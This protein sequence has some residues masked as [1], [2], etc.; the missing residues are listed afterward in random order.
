MAT[1]ELADL[2]AFPEGMN[3][4]AKLWAIPDS[5][6]RW[7]ED[8][9]LDKENEVDR[10][11]PVKP[12][13]VWPTSMT[14]K[15][16]GLVATDDPAYRWRVAVLH[17]TATT[18]K[19]SILSTS[20]S[21]LTEIQWA[22][23]EGV[24]FDPV[25]R[26]KVAT[27]IHPR[28]GALIG[29]QNFASQRGQTSLAHWGGAAKEVY[30][31]GTVTV[32]QDATAVSSS[33]AA[34]TGNIEAGMFLYA[35]CDIATG[36]GKNYIGQVSSFTN[37]TITLVEGALFAVTARA[38]Q[39][40]SLRPLDRRIA[41]GTITCTTSSATVNGANTK[42]KRQG[43]AASA[44]NDK[45]AL[46]RADDMKYIGLISSVASDIQ[47]TLNANAAFACNKDEFIAINMKGDLTKQTTDASDFGWITAQF[48][49]R[50][51]YGNNPYSNK[52]QPFSA[53]RVWFS[54]LFDP[55]ALDHTSD[56]DHV[57]IPSSHP[58]IRPITAMIG[59]PTCLAVFKEDEVYG[60]FGTDESNFSVRKIDCPDG[61]LGPMTLQRYQDGVIFAG[62][63]G[64][65]FFDGNECFDITDERIQ[66]WYE[67]SMEGAQARTYGV[68]SMLYKDTYF[69][70][71]DKATPPTG[72]D[73]T[74]NQTNTENGT[75]ADHL[76]LAVNLSRRAFSTLTNFSFQG[77]IRSPDEET[78]GTIYL[79]NKCADT[80]PFA[81]TGAR[82]CAASDL[83]YTEGLD[84]ITT[85]LRNKYANQLGPDLF[86]ES[87]RYDVGMAQLKKRFK[88][89]QMQYR[90]DT[91]SGNFI[92]TGLTGAGQTDYDDNYLKFATMMGF[93]EMTT[94]SGSK[95]HPTRAANGSGVWKAAFQNKK[96]K[97]NKRSTHIGFKIWQANKTGIKVVRI[98][99][100]ALGYKRMRPGHI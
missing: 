34:F 11:G 66:D 80:T 49:G 29:V 36:S 61:S 38:Y 88:Q 81:L 100:M 83:F 92:S 87:K 91:I 77:A 89:L 35:V 8:V 13:A 24:F 93:N 45:W 14:E 53:S 32:A 22:T 98:G 50:C 47:L 2:P 6:A 52:S 78:Q 23:G 65:W 51:W 62:S 70:Y 55:E 85:D 5:Q 59:L 44:P 58:P 40:R 17:G 95:W 25:G 30:G 64:I 67:K 73:R 90:L 68:W 39:L 28:G 56:G 20:Y 94:V 48:A 15:G 31:T 18:S 43:V 84:T 9:M 82:F 7:L 33:G 1:I 41:K 54:D 99:P 26:Y 69:L 19:L 3:Q 12:M 10:R 74:D 4:Q 57:L 86:I 42:F 46:F 21:S 60:I 71:S 16:I 79:V 97:F 63:R 76:A 75:V 72:P 96:I 27:S 37:T